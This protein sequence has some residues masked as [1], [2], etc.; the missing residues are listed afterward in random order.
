[1]LILECRGR[2]SK[3]ATLG[4]GRGLHR[5]VAGLPSFPPYNIRHDELLLRT[6]LAPSLKSEVRRLMERSVGVRGPV[7]P[8]SRE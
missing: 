4:H 7:G 1:M 8:A 2:L 3:F 6:D 5:L